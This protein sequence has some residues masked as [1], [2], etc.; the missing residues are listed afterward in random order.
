Q[1]EL[2]GLRA[3]LEALEDQVDLATLNVSL[4]EHR[5]LPAGPV[6]FWDGLLTGLESLA[7]VGTGA[8][9][10]LGVLTPWLLLGAVVAVAV[11][12]IVRV[13]RRRSRPRPAPTIEHSPMAERA[14]SEEPRG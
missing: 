13:A 10:V 3:Q 1:Q 14:G 4:T 9:V 11:V 12:L 2:D 5:V 7:V 6:T 8:L